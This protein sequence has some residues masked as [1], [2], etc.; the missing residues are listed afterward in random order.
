MKLR[1]LD[2]KFVQ[3]CK[4]HNRAAMQAN[5]GSE[6][7][8]GEGHAGSPP[9]ITQTREQELVSER[10]DFHDATGHT[11]RPTAVHTSRD[12]RVQRR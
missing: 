11:E 4:P 5:S 6:A 1:G 10:C 12:P 7:G 3:S 8:D 9:A 2:F